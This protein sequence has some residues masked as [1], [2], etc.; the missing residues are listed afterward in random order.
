MKNYIVHDEW[1][2]IEEGFRPAYNEVSESLF[3]IGNG[4]MGQR[5]NFEEDYSGKT[6]S[7]S[8]LAGIYYPDKTRV[9]WWKNG[10]PEYFAKVINAVNWIGLHVKINDELLDL[11]NCEVRSFQRRLD[12]KNGLLIRSFD[13]KLQ[14]G[15]EVR[16][17]S[18]RIF[19]LFQ[20][21]TASLK[22]TIQVLNQQASL[23]VVSYME[24]DVVNRDSNYDEHFWSFISSGSLNSQLQ[25]TMKTKKTNFIVRADL[26]NKFTINDGAIESEL[27]KEGSCISETV[28]VSVGINDVFSIEKR[29]SIVSSQNHAAAELMS[30][31]KANLENI[32]SLSYQEIRNKQALAWGNFWNES[33]IQITGDV[34]AQQA[35]RF[36][37]FQLYQTYTG[38][39]SRLNIGPKG[40]TGEK[41][42][43]VT[44][45]DTEAYCVPFYLATQP[46]DVARNLLL[47]R[48]QHLDKAIENATKLGFSNGAA[49]YPMVTMNGEECHNEWEI[50]FEEIHRN[51]AIA[52][53]IYNYQRYT[54]DWSYIEN[55]GLEVLIA[56]SRFWAQRVNWSA[57]KEK[58]VILGVTGP[59]EYENNV[60]NN[61]YT[62]TI[63]GW[64][65]KYTLESILTL[66]DS[67]HTKL[68]CL[69]EKVGFNSEE[70]VQWQHIIDYLYYPIDTE[71]DIFLQ[72][73]G[74]LDKE[75][76]LVSDLLEKERPIN[77]KW[78]W[79]R[80]LRSCFIKQAD[81]LQGLY[82]FEDQYDLETIRR[83][84]DFY[85]PR[86]V[87]ESSLSP[88]VHAIL[89]SKLGNEAKAY[90][91]YLRTARLDL[92][93]YNNDTEDGLHITSMAGSWMSIVEGFA[94]MRVKDNTLSFQTFIP[95][96]WESYA[97][98]VQF[99]GVKLFVK[100]KQDDFE[101]INKSNQ[102][103]SVIFNGEAGTVKPCA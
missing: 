95:K 57:E 77:Q 60:N 16:I 32:S 25:V 81:V 34:A 5:A 24:G 33:D 102:E 11:A 53:A 15:T 75:Q 30:L 40:F 9:G 56:I 45:W 69:F 63:A 72:Q 47:Y 89:A 98:H 26:V 6:L 19:H 35:I 101:L 17:E 100:I 66:K 85:E 23:Q 86:T 22:Y 20:S 96:T 28:A 76:V 55:Y 3:S 61:W 88:C 8:Y 39:D 71:L 74:Y 93:D 82:F 14:N 12:M 99:R 37:I 103:I 49:L 51:G 52:F 97:F 48:Y 80:I 70:S 10:Y 62:N 27:S 44:Y 41:Y 21:E 4:R 73:D 46:A 91:F 58:Y 90:E 59:N 64:C 2:I 18:T 42:G 94:G 87:H 54:G 7:G 78:S 36:N 43:G 1:N 83:N 79:D 50:T 68:V 67:N 38:E 92:D 29:V 31:G 84:Y 65:L 13:A